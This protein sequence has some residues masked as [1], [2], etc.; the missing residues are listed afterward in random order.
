[1]IDLLTSLK[2]SDVSNNQKEEVS[3]H[4]FLQGSIWEGLERTKSV[5]GKGTFKSVDGWN[6]KGNFFYNGDF[7]G[8]L[9]HFTGVKFIGTWIQ[10][11]FTKGEILFIDGDVLTGEW[12][13][14]DDIWSLKKGVLKSSGRE[15]ELCFDFPLI[16]KNKCFYKNFNGLGFNIVWQDSIMTKEGEVFDLSI[17]ANSSYSYKILKKGESSVHTKILNAVLP[18]EIVESLEKSDQPILRYILPIGINIE[19]R[20]SEDFY[21]TFKKCPNI[22]LRGTFVNNLLS[23]KIKGTLY[24]KD[25]IDSKTIGSLVIKLDSN[26]SLIIKLNSK[27]FKSLD[28]FYRHIKEFNEKKEKCDKIPTEAIIENNQNK[29]SN[30][31]RN[32]AMD[33]KNESKCEIF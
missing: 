11:R 27:M 25:K 9:E 19:K 4:L 22:F 18:Y 1:M 28:A 30:L 23:F 5:L 10:G 3:K 7:E 32:V 14:I 8:E 21:F 16:L 33:I 31:I 12:G 26:D 20:S 17:G 15:L 24:K 2:F 6:C 13:T 29:S